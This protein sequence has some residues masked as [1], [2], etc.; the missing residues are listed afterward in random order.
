MSF[1]LRARPALSDCPIS[2]W[3]VPAPDVSTSYDR[4]VDESGQG[5]RDTRLWKR[6]ELSIHEM[7]AALDPHA[8][9]RHNEH[10]E[11][12]LSGRMRQIDVLA[13][14]SVAG[15]EITVVVECKRYRRSV[16]IGDVD[17]FIGKI[18]DVGGERGILYSYSGFTDGAVARAIGAA[19]P[20]VLTIALETPKIVSELRG[21]PGY[22]A[23]LLV[24][25]VPPLWIEDLGRDDFALYLRTGDWAD[26]AL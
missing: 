1:A 13:K 19:N 22:L 14:G 5:D 11:G 3:Q 7:L 8:E 23:R 17:Q 16:A 10:V 20:S 2:V 12:R 15:V 25:H 4:I 9:V 26:F 18:I 6:Y 24:Q 21:A